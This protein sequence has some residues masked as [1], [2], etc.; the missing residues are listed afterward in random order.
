MAASFQEQVY[1]LILQIPRGKVSTY[2][3]IAEALHCKAY[4]AV[5]TALNKNPNGFVNPLT[6]N[7]VPCHRV[8]NVDGSLGGFAYGSSV[9]KEFLEKEGLIIQ[10]NKI[11]DFEKV[12]FQF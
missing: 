5:G 11:V 8:V 1:A 12:L 7:P 6:D 4:Q 9:K 2:K 3:A 10:N